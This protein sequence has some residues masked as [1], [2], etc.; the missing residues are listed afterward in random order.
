MPPKLGDIHRRPRSD[1]GVVRLWEWARGKRGSWT[2]A[3]A[4]EAAEIAPRRAR[5]IIKA[6]CD[7][8][9]I[10][11]TAE[12]ESIGGPDGATPAEYRFSAAARDLPGAPVLIVDGESG[13]ITGVRAPAD[14]DGNARLRAAVDASGL[15]GRAA[16]AAL[17]LNERTLRRMISGET[18]IGR[19]DPA[20]A[21][22]PAL[23][24]RA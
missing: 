4:A 9:Y 21:R 2:A 6:L 20:L 13:T 18:P 10:D 19:D 3:E 14:G 7:A 5:A 1:S 12:A 16:A 15:S 24:P 17:G 11:L 22:L 23:K 8:G